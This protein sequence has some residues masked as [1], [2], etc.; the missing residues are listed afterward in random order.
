MISAQ[1]R[2]LTRISSCLKLDKKNPEH[3]HIELDAIITY[4][5]NYGLSV[6]GQQYEALVKK[7]LREQIKNKAQL[8]EPYIF[9]KIA[10]ALIELASNLIISAELSFQKHLETVPEEVRERYMKDM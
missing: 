1:S 9:K 6:P 2:L 10:S 8:T 3:L 5:D 7:M 4:L